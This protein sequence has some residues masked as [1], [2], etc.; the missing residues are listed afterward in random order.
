MW[1]LCSDSSGGEKCATIFKFIFVEGVFSELILLALAKR[2]TPGAK[3]PTLRR[4][5]RPKAKALG[6]LEAGAKA[7]FVGQKRRAK[8]AETKAKTKIQGS[9]ASLRMTAAPRRWR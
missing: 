1:C 6:Y 5:G 3:A 8:E 7:R 2:H 9:F 4:I